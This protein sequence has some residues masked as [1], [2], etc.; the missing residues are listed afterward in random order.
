L[1]LTV[2]MSEYER[3]QFT[4]KGSTQVDREKLRKYWFRAI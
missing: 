3:P 4:F 1:E 2:A